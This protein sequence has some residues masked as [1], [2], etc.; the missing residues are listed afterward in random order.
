MKSKK[1]FFESKRNVILT[2]LIYTFL[3][4]CAFPLVKICMDAFG[5]ASDD[6]MSKC[7]VAGI[8]F[9]FSGVLTLAW[10]FF[11]DKSRLAVPVPQIKNIFL[12]ALL[13]TALQ[14]SFTYIGLSR[15]DGSKGAVFDQLCVF[16]I[17]LFGGLFFKDDKLNWKKVVGCILGFAGVLV[18]NTDGISFE[19]SVFGEGIML[20]A[21]LCQTASYFVAKSSS[22]TLSA[23]KLVGYGQAIGGACLCVFA[24]LC[25]GRIETVGKT[26][27]LT[28]VG[29]IFISAVAYVLSLM[30]LKYFP[31]SEISS[32]N[33]LIT[34]FGV[35]MSGIVLGENILR[36][37]YLLSLL[38]IG[39]GIAFINRS[40]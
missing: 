23:A 5:I 14:Y 15:I 16:L 34:V 27:V 7:L 20:L 26:A 29:L 3:W 40:K 2:A 4:G 13:A 30:P 17:V 6:N 24:Y 35:V 28:L 1:S 21:V 32:F 33:L 36:W 9:L 22:S 37:N 25:G 10:C 31:A 8:R 18:I 19:F 12:Y 38:L 11:T 39:G